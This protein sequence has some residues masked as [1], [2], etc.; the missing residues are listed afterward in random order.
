MRIERTGPWYASVGRGVI[1]AL[2][3]LAVPVAKAQEKD[4]G[5]GDRKSAP[6]GLIT[7]NPP[8][9]DPDQGGA[10]AE[11][12]VVFEKA[13]REY[14]GQY[15]TAELFQDDVFV[16]VLQDL[17]QSKLTPE[18]KVDAFILMQQRIGWLFVGM[19]QMPPK[20]AYARWSGAQVSTYFQ[21]AFVM[22]QGID[23]ADLLELA[24]V[25]DERWTTDPL[26][27]S[28]A[29]LLA[30][31]LNH[32]AAGAAVA[33]AIDL[34]AVRATP[35][36]PITIHNLAFAAM[37]TRDPE[38]VHRMIVWLPE[39]IYE[40][41]REDLVNLAMVYRTDPVKDALEQFVT[42]AKAD[43]NDNAVVGALKALSAITPEERFEAFFQARLTEVDPERRAE[44]ESLRDQQFPDRLARRTL[45]EG[46]SMT[47]IW[48]GFVLQ[49]LSDRFVIE[50]SDRFRYTDHSRKTER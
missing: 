19:V 36:P 40:E 8:E 43:F 1:V 29:L 20:W 23:V 27:P 34:E 35:V 22:P 11:D 42:E 33:K 9:A 21:Y 38:Q 18:A 3:V 6:E 14:V 4:D 32:E 13:A 28:N 48:D 25:E 41:S 44:F 47:K 45:A 30:S 46:M 39:V 50:F 12:T 10:P 31:I 5:A 15:T 7:G 16:E 2:L 24:D 49:A 37:L 26:R 17:A